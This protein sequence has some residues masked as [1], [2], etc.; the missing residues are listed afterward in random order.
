MGNIFVVEGAVKSDGLK[1][2][3]PLPFVV[4]HS[5]KITKTRLGYCLSSELRSVSLALA[6]GSYCGYWKAR[7][8]A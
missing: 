6:G 5:G 8:R 7:Q 1:A 2:S 4:V 3:V